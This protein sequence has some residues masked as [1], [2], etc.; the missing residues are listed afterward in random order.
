MIDIRKTGFSL[1]GGNAGLLVNGS[2]LSKK[3]QPCP[4]KIVLR[5]YK[6]EPAIDRRAAVTF[7]LG[8]A[9]EEVFASEH[10]WCAM[11]FRL[12]ERPQVTKNV[13]LGLEADAIDLQ[14]KLLWELKTVSSTSK[15]KE[16]LINGEYSL[17]NAVQMGTYMYLFNALEVPV[18][19]GVLRYT[20]AIYDSLTVAKVK[21]R[22][23][24]GDVHDFR[25]TWD[26]DRLLIDGKP[27]PVT[28]SGISRFIE[29][30]ASVLE[31]DIKFSDVLKPSFEGEY[32]ACQWC[33]MRE[34]CNHA[35]ERGFDWEEFIQHCAQEVGVRNRESEKSL[36]LS[37]LPKVLRDNVAEVDYEIL[38]LWCGEKYEKVLA[39]AELTVE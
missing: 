35:E 18:E 11:N 14:R 15:I 17:D 4:R 7:A 33:S 37:M 32:I 26:G 9:M 23:A 16:Y 38:R 3:D 19:Q 22:I 10:P 29:Y 25:A 36:M 2:I 27:S 8:R 12:P 1:A 28:A 21:H 34:C 24:A 30:M 20:S 31:G 6:I 39:A 13:C 5:Q